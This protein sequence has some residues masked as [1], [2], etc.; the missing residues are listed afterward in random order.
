MF[1]PANLDSRNELI[2]KE[3]NVLDFGKIVLMEVMGDDNSIVQNARTSYHPDST[4]TLSDDKTLLRYLFRH[5]HTTPFGTGQCVK[6]FFSLPILVER[7]MARHR[8]ANW[9][10]VSARYSVLPEKFYI[11]EPA[12][13]CHQDKK[14]R[15]GRAE[16]LDEET[17]NLIITEQREFCEDAFRIYRRHLDLGLARETARDILPFCT[18]TEKVWSMD[19]HNM[20]HFLS[21]RMDSHAQYEIRVFAEVIGNEIIAKLWPISWQA[22]LDYRLNAMQLSSIDIMIIQELMPEANYDDF[23]WASNYAMPEWKG[24]ERCRERDECLEKLKI[25]GLV[26]VD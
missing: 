26:N 17:A 13:V 25:L 15:Q 9:N 4:K 16:P 19:L 7:Q 20:F 21:L 14:N 24:L 10:E 5:R 1:E 12:Q 23:V 8:T 11:P 2:G 22:F 3:F 6:M 18:Y